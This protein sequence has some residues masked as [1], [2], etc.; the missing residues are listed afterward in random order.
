VKRTCDVIPL[1]VF[2]LVG[3]SAWAD[4]AKQDLRTMEGTWNV[5]SKEENGKSADVE[6]GL[7]LVVNPDST[8][9]VKAGDK[10]V[11]A[12]SIKLDPSSK[13]KSVEVTY[14]DGPDKGKVFKGIYIIAGDTAK[15]CR[16]GP[17]EHGRPSEFKTKANSGQVR[18]EYQRAK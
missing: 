13:P 3:L 6:S 16:A 9:V 15:F 2:A 18:Y 5:V 14:T 10:I 12:G 11:E 1:L 7:Q 4:D 8:F 17:Q